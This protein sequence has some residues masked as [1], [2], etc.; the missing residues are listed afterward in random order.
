MHQ[1]IIGNVDVRTARGQR[2]FELLCS[3]GSSSSYGGDFESGRS[4]RHDAIQLV[5]WGAVPTP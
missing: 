3:T 2:E 5:C 1:C 4:R